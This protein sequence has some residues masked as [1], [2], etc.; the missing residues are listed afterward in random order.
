MK[1]DSR[2]ALCAD[3]VTGD[4][5]CDVGTDHGLL[6]AALLVSGKC[7]RAV[8]SDINPMPLAAAREN[9][10]KYGVADRAET[11]LADGLSGV[12]LKGVTDIVIAGMGGENIAKIISDGMAKGIVF[13]AAL[14][15]QPM[16]RAE[17]LRE[18]LAEKGFEVTGEKG[19]ISGGFAYT[20]MRCI[21]TG[22]ARELSPE[23]RITG[24]LSRDLPDDREYVKKQLMRYEK[25]L[26]GAEKQ[27]RETAAVMRSLSEKIRKEWE[28]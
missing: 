20:V 28:L 16:S 1:L 18:F 25:R 14:V 26:L 21:H 10:L 9:L 15:L 12:P 3:T 13:T 23:E 4:F 5:V 19:V 7:R 22:K 27:D 8:C 17:I 6:P 24:R 11:Y 2:L